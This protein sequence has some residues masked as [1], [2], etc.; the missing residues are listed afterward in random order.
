MRLHTGWM[1]GAI[2]AVILNGAA[3]ADVTVSQSNDP[4]AAIG[5]AL[6][7][8]LGAEKQALAALPEQRL[9]ELAVGP[10]IETKTTT[11]KA[12]GKD[13]APAVIRYDD[14]WLAQLPEPSGD[15]EWEC[16][17]TAIYFESRGE[18]LRGQFAVA[19]VILN[20]VDSPDYPKSICAV[21]QQGGS[22]GCQFSY[23]CDG[24]ADA[25]RDPEATWRAGRIA[26]VM[27]D[28][29]PRALTMGATHFH[30]RAVRPGWSNRFPQ[31]ASI[32]AHLFYRQP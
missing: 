14:A 18:T 13:A 4:T 3:F 21:V 16:L 31:T 32:G 15:A 12:R 10:E 25:M 17:R 5:G 20:R 26:R 19:E 8:L 29:A 23:S 2:A 28:G 6:T 27:M 22:G 30:T 24:R 1:T 7:S 11:A 9:T